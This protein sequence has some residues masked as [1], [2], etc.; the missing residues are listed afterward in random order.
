VI[1]KF[2]AILPF[3]AAFSSSRRGF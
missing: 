2:T 1:Q 3:F